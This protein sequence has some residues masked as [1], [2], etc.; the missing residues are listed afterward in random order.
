M[1]SVEERWNSGLPINLKELAVVMSVS[2]KTATGWAKDDSFPRVGR[3]LMKRDFLRWWKKK[4]SSADTASHRPLPADCKS[5]EPLPK[6][7]SQVAWPPRAA[8][9]RREI[10]RQLYKNP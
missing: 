3:Y 8:R 1:K 6:N 7:D 2:Y 5:H 10:E 4:A 9:L